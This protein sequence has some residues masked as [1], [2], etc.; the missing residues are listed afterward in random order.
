V[1][2]IV[3]IGASGQVGSALVAEAQRRGLALTRAG[4]R[5][6]VRVDLED[7]A[8]L[9]TVFASRPDAVLLAAGYT[10]VDGAEREPERAMVVNARA[11]EA[12]AREAARLGVR[13]VYFSTDYVFAGGADPYHEDDPTA[14]ATVYGKSKRQGELAV[15]CHTGHLV[16]RTSVV[17]GVDPGEKNFIYQ[18]LRAARER[19]RLKVASDQ[20]SNPTFTEELAWASLELLERGTSGIVHAVGPLALTRP[21]LG[22][23]AGRTFGFDAAAV[24]DVTTTSGLGQVAPRPLRVSLADDK[25]R[26]VLGRPLAAPAEGLR[27]MREAMS[28]EA[29]VS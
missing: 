23:L 15:L 24:M 7:N 17:Y 2:R 4:R 28:S 13:V 16:V 8:S 21:E 26:R 18:L 5:E 12:L 29:R 10:Y 6:P 22:E 1:Q 19:R 14:P 20:R 9:D 3:I 11:P 25:L 27:R